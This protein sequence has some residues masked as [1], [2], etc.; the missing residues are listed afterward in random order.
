MKIIFAG[1][2][3]FAAAALAALHAHGHQIALVLTQ[4]DRAAG[5]GMKLKVSA[6]AETALKLG[7]PLA[8]PDSL[9]GE[10]IQ[11]T[12]RTV[13][14]DVM[15]V[16]AYGLIL[17]QSVLDIPKYGCINIHASLLPRWRGAAPVQRA[18]EAG[19]SETGIAIMQMNAGLDTGPVLLTR[20]CEILPDET[21]ATLFPKLTLV[22]ATAIVDAIEKLHLLK[23]IAQPA[24]GV[25]YARKIGKTDSRV[26]WH[27][28]AQEIER[29]M[30]AFDPTP[31]CESSIAD[32]QLKIWRATQN[33]ARDD[34]SVAP[35]TVTSVTQDSLTVQ[36]GVGA[37]NLIT[38]QKTGGKRM[39]IADF[40]RGITIQTGSRFL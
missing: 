17:P 7:L 27:L 1:T 21:S 26:D 37:L 34:G 25:T 36:C 6:V 31:G 15:V 5:R 28:P 2:P 35:G 38:V 40:L 11:M 3:A 13:A 10:A 32:V 23:A 24:A 16:A 30:R 39:A 19:D 9:K 20:T 33:L 12:L 18:I 14:P 8:K 4:P 29:R 22:A